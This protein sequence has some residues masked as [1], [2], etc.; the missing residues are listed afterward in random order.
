MFSGET[1]QS[2]A[3]FASGYAKRWLDQQYDKLDDVAL[4]QQ[5]KALDPKIKYAI[6]AGLYGVLAYLDRKCACDTPLKKFF[7]EVVT[8]I[9]PELA[10]RLVTAVREDITKDVATANAETKPALQT[11]LQLDDTQL[12]EVLNWLGSLSKSE[13]TKRLQQIQKLS[14]EQLA[15]IAALSAEERDALFGTTTKTSTPILGKVTESMKA[16]RTRLQEKSREL[17]SKQTW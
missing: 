5:A 11:L 4:W 7:R 2:F 1:R 14:Q 3:V 12:R 10:K 6:E 17:Q 8:D 13:R 9:P 15:R 16:A